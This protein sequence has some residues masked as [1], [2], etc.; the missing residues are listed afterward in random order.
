MRS[1]T[2]SHPSAALPEHCCLS[3]PECAIFQTHLLLLFLT[4]L[5]SKQFK[6]D[7]EFEAR[8]QTQSMNRKNRDISLQYKL[9]LIWCHW[10]W[11]RTSGGLFASHISFSFPPLVSDSLSLSPPSALFLSHPRT[12]LSFILFILF[13]VSF[14]GTACPLKGSLFLSLSQMCFLLLRLFLSPVISP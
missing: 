7:L 2:Q 6:G 4:F 11:R 5:F 12:H 3:A 10:T 13:I 8:M 9:F 1:Q 14:S